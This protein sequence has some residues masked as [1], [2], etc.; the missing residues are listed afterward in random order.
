MGF[1]E[2]MLSAE[3]EFHR[4]TVFDRT[5][6][7]AIDVHEPVEGICLR[8][9]GAQMFVEFQHARIKPQKKAGGNRDACAG[10]EISNLRFEIGI[11]CSGALLHHSLNN[12]HRALVATIQVFAQRVGDA[13]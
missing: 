1:D 3:I 7:L 12:F 11:L 4:A 9:I 2:V 13:I 8:H 5:M 10:F 6:H